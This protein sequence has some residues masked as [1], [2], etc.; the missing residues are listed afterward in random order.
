LK[1]LIETQ[2]RPEKTDHIYFV[3]DLIDRG[4]RSREVLDYIIDLKWKGFSAFAVRG[5]HE[6]LF[7]KAFSKSAYMQ[8]WFLNGA[9]ETM[10]SFDIPE[11]KLNDFEGMRL[12]PDRYI[13]FLEGLPYFYDLKDFIIVHAGLNLTAMDFFGDTQT[14]LW[15]R[16]IKGLNLLN[17]G[18]AIIHGHTPTPLETIKSNLSQKDSKNLNIDA[19]C[20]YK[21]VPG[22]GFLVALEL[23]NREF[24]VQENID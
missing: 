6:D 19:G 13:Q 4:P 5:N 10:R 7:V 1:K 3:G 8:A 9:E 22:Y 23:N 16:E 17:D 14:M 11:D 15:G 24:F 2:V 12:I 21:D 18:T 20:V